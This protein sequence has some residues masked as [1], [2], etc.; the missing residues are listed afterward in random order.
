MKKIILSVCALSAMV[1][2]S[3]SNEVDMFETIGT[4]KAT[5]ELNISNDKEMQVATRASDKV[6]DN[7]TWYAK[8]GSNQQCTVSALID[9]TYTPNTS[10]QL[11]VSNYQNLDAALKSNNG[12]GD[13]FF[14]KTQQITLERGTNTITV[15]CGTAQNSMLTVNWSGTSGVQ[16]LSMTNVEASQPSRTKYTYSNASSNQSAYF[17]AGED[18]TC[19]INYTYNGATKT[20]SKTFSKPLAAYEYK[21]KV[22]ANNNGTITTITINYDNTFDDGGTTDFIINAATGEEVTTPSAK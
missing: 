1:L 12:A 5:I 3:C 11:T 6:A 16:G 13:M 18:I 15:D 2:T 4:P 20:L 9:K 21:L 22:S 7:S 17:K 10:Y 8:L 14:T 19:T